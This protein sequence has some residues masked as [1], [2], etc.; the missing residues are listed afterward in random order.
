MK[1]FKFFRYRSKLVDILDDCIVYVYTA[2]L[3]SVYYICFFFHTFILL[4]AS[5]SYIIKVQNIEC[6]KPFYA[7]WFSGILLYDYIEKCVFFANKIRFDPKL[8]ASFNIKK[9]QK[10]KKKVA[11]VQIF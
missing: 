11:K 5:Y 6:C 4:H 1:K 9:K 10:K 7:I 3:Y 8:F 2:A